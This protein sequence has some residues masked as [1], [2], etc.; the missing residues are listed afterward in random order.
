MNTSNYKIAVK[1]DPQSRF[2]LIVE[3]VD[4][5]LRLF[6]K[7]KE[8]FSVRKKQIPSEPF[9]LKPRRKYLLRYNNNDSG[10]GYLKYKI[11]QILPNGIEEE[12]LEADLQAI[13][14]PQV[15]EIPFMLWPGEE[16]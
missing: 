15:V 10:E 9:E 2:F 6:W 13:D 11:L 1:K 12:V 14:G 8:F 5:E 7:R 16:A 4:Y 3:R